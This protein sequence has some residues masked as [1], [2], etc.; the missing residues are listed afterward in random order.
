MRGGLSA[1]FGDVADTTPEEERGEVFGQIGATVGAGFIIG[2]A[3]GGLASHLSLN[4]AMFLAAGVSLLNLLWGAF[5]LPESLSPEKRSKHF[6]AAHLNPLRQ[7]SRALAYPAVRRLVSVSVLFI[8]PFSSMQVALSLL[9]RG[10]LGWGPA[11]V[12]TA[13]I[14]VGCCDIV[15][16]GLL[17]PHLRKRLGERG[18]ALLGLSLGVMGMVCVWRCCPRSPSR[19]CCTSA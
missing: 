13:F 15:A 3:I 1:I 17:L 5:V 11:Q 19:A 2:P 4:A 8:L 7:R 6:D 16:Q 9:G 18:V 10:T 14:R 12:S